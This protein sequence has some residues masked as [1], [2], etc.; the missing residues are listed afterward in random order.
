MLPDALPH[1]GTATLE[2]FVVSPVHRYEGR[3]SDGARPSRGHETP[4]RITVRAHLGAVGDRY[5]GHPAHRLA[6]VTLLAAESLDAVARELAPSRPL[7]PAATRRTIVVRGLAVDALRGATLSL[8]TG[9]GPVVLRLNRPAHPCAWM[10]SELAPGAFR[11]LRGR[12][13]MRCEPL[14]DGTLTLGAA[15]VRCDVPLPPADGAGVAVR[16]AAPQASGAR[17]PSDRTSASWAIAGSGETG[18]AGIARGA[19]DG[20][21]R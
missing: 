10:D 19:G 21:R 3:P 18:T 7:D 5:F 12:G 6:S 4:E 9:D 11:A 1:A 16:P 20:S 2:L 17:H 14:T 8:D 13:G 15:R